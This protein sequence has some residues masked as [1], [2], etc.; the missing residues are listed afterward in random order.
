M[1]GAPPGAAVV[2]PDV[3]ARE[4]FC[5]VD[6]AARFR[7]QRRRG[8]VKRLFPLFDGS[9]K[10]KEGRSAVSSVCDFEAVSLRQL[11]IENR[12]DVSKTGANYISLGSPR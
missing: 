4:G 1:C 12:M 3:C 10:G 9:V 5:S 2:T 6:A 8:C 11:G 7:L